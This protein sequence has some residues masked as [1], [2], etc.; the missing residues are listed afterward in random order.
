MEQLHL[1]EA[2]DERPFPAAIPDY[3]QLLL[4]PHSSETSRQPDIAVVS[5]PTPAQVFPET[6]YDYDVPAV[7]HPDVDKIL[8][9]LDK[10][11]WKDG[12]PFPDCK[13]ADSIISSHHGDYSFSTELARLF[14]LV[15][16]CREAIDAVVDV[17]KKH[18]IPGILEVN[19]AHNNGYLSKAFHLAGIDCIAAAPRPEYRPIRHYPIEKRN[20]G[21]A[22]TSHQ[23]RTYQFYHDR[24]VLLGYSKPSYKVLSAEGKIVDGA[25]VVNNNGLKIMLDGKELE[26]ART[27]YGI[28]ATG[29]CVLNGLR[30]G[31]I[32]IHVDYHTDPDPRR[33]DLDYSIDPDLLKAI[34]SC[35]RQIGKDIPLPRDPFGRKITLRIFERNGCSPTV[36]PYRECATVRAN[37]SASY[38]HNRLDLH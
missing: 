5:R 6:T 2:I 24:A 19:A 17:L 35:C 14:G 31:N 25:T 21:D 13:T 10:D 34:Y 33:P 32:L 30:E 18:N 9:W 22:I 8:H 16:L 12:N 26:G 4:L 7:T 28:S 1:S 15:V 20:A 27:Q 38:A 11:A 29:L 3:D 23:D 36:S 37:G